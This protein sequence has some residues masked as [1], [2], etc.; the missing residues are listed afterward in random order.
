MAFSTPV[1]VPNRAPLLALTS[2]PGLTQPT[3]A[4]RVYGLR[5]AL[6]MYWSVACWLSKRASDGG[7]RCPNGGDGRSVP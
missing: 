1:L 5:S 2:W 6:R 7:V 3:P 4:D